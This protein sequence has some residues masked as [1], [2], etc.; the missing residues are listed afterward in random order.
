[1]TG[2][3]PASMMRLQRILPRRNRPAYSFDAIDAQG[4]P[5]K[6]VLEAD[7]AWGA[8]PMLRA[9]ALI[10]LSVSLV[11]GAPAAASGGAGNWG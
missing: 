10:Q 6:G 5:R 3:A 7:T 8:C 9:Q 11:G 1:M 4:L 2:L